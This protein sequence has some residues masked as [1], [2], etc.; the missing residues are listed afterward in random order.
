M[1]KFKETHSRSFLKMITWRIGASCIT[2]GISYLVTGSLGGAGKIAGA[3]FFA[4]SLYYFIHERIWNKADSGKLA[5]EI[6]E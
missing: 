3:L 4:N 5:K 1:F 2:F 6:K